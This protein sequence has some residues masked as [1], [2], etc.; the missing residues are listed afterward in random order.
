MP[1]PAPWKNLAD[2]TSNEK[3]QTR[4]HAERTVP[5]RWDLKLINGAKSQ[6][7]GY[8]WEGEYRLEDTRQNSHGGWK[9]SLS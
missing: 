5:F 7:H 8:F 6:D 3:S 1:H 4:K 2:V 9:C